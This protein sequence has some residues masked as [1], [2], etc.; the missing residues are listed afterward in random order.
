MIIARTIEKYIA[1]NS[2]GILKVGPIIRAASR[3]IAPLI[4]NENNPSVIKLTGMETNMNTGLMVW[5]INAIT[6]ATKRA[7][8]RV[9]AIELKVKTNGTPT[10]V[11]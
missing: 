1:I 6:T 9:L 3:I 8:Q 7:V 10:L 4:T 2:P 5:L 11:I